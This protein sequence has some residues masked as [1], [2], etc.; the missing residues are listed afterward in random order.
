MLMLS[1]IIKGRQQLFSY[2]PLDQLRVTPIGVVG[3][4]SPQIFEI[5]GIDNSHIATLM[6]PSMIETE[7]WIKLLKIQI[8]LF[9]QEKYSRLMKV[10]K[11]K[12]LERKAS[13]SSNT[14]HRYQK[15][16]YVLLEGHRYRSYLLRLKQVKKRVI[17]FLQGKIIY[18]AL[19]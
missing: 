11:Q 15:A 7:E 5:R 4:E 19:E 1:G 13:E 6:C 9:H 16:S 12:K 18:L 2:K 10:E 8:L 14:V 17:G 3:D